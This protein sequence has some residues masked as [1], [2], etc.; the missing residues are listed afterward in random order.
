MP[1]PRRS[2][3][4]NFSY[5]TG[6]FEIPIQHSLIRDRPPG[7]DHAHWIPTRPARRPGWIVEDPATFLE[8]RVDTAG[9]ATEIR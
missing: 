6:S 1:I 5:C 2:M 8:I 9:G 4:L 3:T 7:A